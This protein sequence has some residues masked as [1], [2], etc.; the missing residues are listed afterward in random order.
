[1]SFTGSY[2][3]WGGTGLGAYRVVKELKGMYRMMGLQWAS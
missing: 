2:K 3:D 1:M